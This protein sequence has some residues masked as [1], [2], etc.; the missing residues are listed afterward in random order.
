MYLSEYPTYLKAMEHN[1][2]VKLF[3]CHNATGHRINTDLPMSLVMAA[4]SSF[5]LPPSFKTEILSSSSRKSVLNVHYPAKVYET[6]N[7]Q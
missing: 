3:W 2:E 5:K 4:V 6:A 7:F 1:T